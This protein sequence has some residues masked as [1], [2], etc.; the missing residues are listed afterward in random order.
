MTKRSRYLLIVFCV[1]LFAILAPL[2][3]FYSMGLSFDWQKKSLTKTG[4]LAFFTEPKEPKVSLDGKEV[5]QPVSTLRFLKPKDYT[6]KFELP[7][8]CS[9]QKRLPVNPEQVTWASPFDSKIYL[10][11]SA[12]NT[13][14]LATGTEDFFYKENY[15]FAAKTNSLSVISTKN[16]AEKKFPLEGKLRSI[17]PLNNS[18][19]FLLEL[20]LT[21]STST[22]SV[23]NQT[24]GTLNK[25][26]GDFSTETKIFTHNND[27]LVFEKNILY[28]LEPKS[29]EKK[30]LL[31]NVLDFVTLFSDGYI[32]TKGDNFS[33]LYNFPLNNIGQINELAKLQSFSKAKIF[34]TEEKQ[35]FILADKKLYELGL[36][37]KNI[38]SAEFAY[39]EQTSPNLI[40]FGQGETFFFDFSSNQQKLISRTS[41]KITNLLLASNLGYAILQKGQKIEALELDTRDAQNNCV[42]YQ[43]QNIIKIFPDEDNHRLF[44]LDGNEL[45]MLEI[46]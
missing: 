9:W 10:L 12:P 16:F 7:G 28:S 20:K 40:Y 4:I 32:L 18:S 6:L 13:N 26:P 17:T 31:K 14:V 19:D 38:G 25:I 1:V 41:E 43:G 30:V 3:I 23:F 22:F 27:Y 34:V 24:L 33:I 8:Y 46:R 37:I 21:A 36:Q 39:F 15:V 29:G 11:K 35:I 5:E 44:V 42:L 2:T 45:K